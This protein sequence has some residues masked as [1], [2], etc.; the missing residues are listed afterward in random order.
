MLF[1]SIAEA[2][3]SLMAPPGVPADRLAVLR[4]AFDAMVAD[5]AFKEEAEKRK[6]ELGPLSGED[7]QKLMRETL[8]LT[9]DMVARAIALSRE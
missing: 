3:R 5:P 4:R 7:M 6:L 8:D 2:G 1:G 9:P